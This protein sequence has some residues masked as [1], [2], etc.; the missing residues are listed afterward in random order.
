ME[1][2]PTTEQLTT[3]F[4]RFTRLG[5]TPSQWA[6]L[7]GRLETAASVSAIARPRLMEM[8]SVCLAAAWDM[9]START[10]SEVAS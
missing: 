4:D 5:A 2:N 9:P 10:Q 6:T 3:C 8:R 7:A 1:T